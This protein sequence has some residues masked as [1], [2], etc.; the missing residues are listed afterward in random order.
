[1]SYYD[2]AHKDL[3]PM[4]LGSTGQKSR[5]VSR[6]RYMRGFRSE[7]PRAPY[8]V[9][10]SDQLADP[11]AWYLSRVYNARKSK[12]ATYVADTGHSVHMED[13]SYH[14]VDFTVGRV[15]GSTHI[16]IPFRGVYFA[17]NSNA[18]NLAGWG[19]AYWHNPVPSYSDLAAFG[20]QAISRRAPA[21]AEF[22]LSQFLGELREGLP[23]ILG[24]ALLK[25]RTKDALKATGGE[26]LNVQFGWL[27][28]V[29]DLKKL[30]Q[31]LLDLEAILSNKR[32]QFGQPQRATFSPPPIQ[33]GDTQSIGLT[34]LTL[35]GG[36]WGGNTLAPTHVRT[37]VNKGYNTAYT[38]L[39]YASDVV[40]IRSGTRERRFTGSFTSSYVYPGADATWL[41][42]ASALISLE[43]TPQVL[44]ELA[45]WSWLV[46]WFFKIQS[47]I[48]SNSVAGDQR[49]VMNYGYVSQKD[50]FRTLI[51][52]KLWYYPNGS[53][54]YM[55]VVG[56]LTEHTYHRR[57]R[58]NPFGFQAASPGE[59]NA[60]QLSILA[61]LGISRV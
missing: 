29:S 37:W 2:E 39:V 21:H 20:Q 40:A 16:P 11:Y 22:S 26:Y 43:V 24:A 36:A 5:T 17:P 12:A 51:T 19:S 3:V 1:M 6:V 30:V 52:G 34:G 54:Q 59:L 58:A 47:T 7:G 18:P 38:S 8:A 35:T 55:P 23:S 14:P 9:P 10:V 56:S 46:D 28:M 53:N 44:W 32:G 50:T 13:H 27:P 15:V 41:E 31:T 49:I 60:H 4:E 61:A 33:I 25:A 42:K 48:E 45:P 57:V